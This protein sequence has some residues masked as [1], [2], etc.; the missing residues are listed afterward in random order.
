M[1]Y[2]MNINNKM[3]DDM[4]ALWVKFR[5]NNLNHNNKVRI[6]NIMFINN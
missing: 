4:S 5:Q 3:K 2:R 1:S 6:V